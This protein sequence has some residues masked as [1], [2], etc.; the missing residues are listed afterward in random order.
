M[1]TALSAEARGACVP[2][3]AEAI[4]YPTSADEVMQVEK[5]VP[6]RS[7]RQLPSSGYFVRFGGGV[8]LPQICS[9][10]RAR[11]QPNL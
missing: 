5:G 11:P 9:R 8:G 6:C 7:P 4:V 2:K 10:R 1:E 3:N